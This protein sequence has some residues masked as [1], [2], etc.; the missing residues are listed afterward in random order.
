MALAGVDTGGLGS[1]SEETAADPTLIRLRDKVEFD[2]QPSPPN[3]VA[4]LEL[5]LTDGSRVSTRYDSGVPATDI[6]EQGRRLEEKFTSI[7]E[8]VVG[9]KKTR[10]LIGLIGRL[11]EL[12]DLRGV[13]ALCVA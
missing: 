4:E 11:D 5:L 1:Y 9:A 10:D 12:P 13:M 7:A 8:P 3:T 6:Q 2:F